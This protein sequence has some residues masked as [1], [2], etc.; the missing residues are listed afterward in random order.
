MRLSGAE[1]VV[2]SLIQEGVTSIFGYPGAAIT[3]IYDHL[4]KSPIRHYLVR[5]EQGAVHMA[6]GYARTSGKVGVCLVTS[7]PGA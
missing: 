2:E 3:D 6:D 1:I 7:G 4:E 5:H